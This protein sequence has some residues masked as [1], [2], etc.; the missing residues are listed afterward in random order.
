MLILTEQT[1]IKFHSKDN[2][3]RNNL[4][5]PICVLCMHVHERAC[6]LNI[7]YGV[8]EVENIEKKDKRRD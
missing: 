3:V 2:I 4:K 7:V 1:V 8:W 5:F 6:G